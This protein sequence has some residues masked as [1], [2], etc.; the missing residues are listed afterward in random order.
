MSFRVLVACEFSGT[1]R[2]AFLAKGHDAWSCDLL[3]DEKGSNRHIRGDVREILNDGW[4]LL[5]VAHPPCT[6]LCNSGVRWLS[7][8]PTKLTAEHYSEAE[9]DAY[10][11]MTRDQR[12]AF[13]WHKL[14]E[15]ASLFSDL[16]NAPIPRK[17]LENPVMHKHAKKRIVNYREFEQSIQPYHFGHRETKRTC[18]WL[19]NLPALQS[20]TP[21]LEREYK[22]LPEAERR[23]WARVHNA[24]PGADRWSERSRFFRGIAEAMATQWSEPQSAP[25][26]FAL[27]L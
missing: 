10:E 22:A 2:E 9:I 15:G 20:T 14:D 19:D 8:P 24:S 21:E 3:P 17:A 5:M 4:D 27:S 26:Q 6:R 13:M 23:K 12:L 16:W 1:V 7:D 18:L 11:T 25:T